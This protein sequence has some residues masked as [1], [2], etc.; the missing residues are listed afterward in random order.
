MNENLLQLSDGIFCS[1]WDAMSE[2]N[3]VFRT[4][5]S[6]HIHTQGLHETWISFSVFYGN[7]ACKVRVLSSIQCNSNRIHSALGWNRIRCNASVTVAISFW[8]H[9][10]QWKE[11]EKYVNSSFMTVISKDNSGFSF[12]GQEL[13]IHCIVQCVDDGCLQLIRNMRI[14]HFELVIQS[15]HR[16]I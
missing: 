12:E 1:K 15:R 2:S 13:H 4:M 6:S 3:S 9:Q 14:T 5:T 7:F 11:N 16:I 8:I 10:M